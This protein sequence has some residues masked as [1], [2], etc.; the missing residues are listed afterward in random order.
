MIRG[1][2]RALSLYRCLASNWSRFGTLRGA[3]HGT[4]P[5]LEES[6]GGLPG[7]DTA[8][9]IPGKYISELHGCESPRACAGK[10]P[11]FAF[12]RHVDADQVGAK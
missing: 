1:M 3:L 2:I 11:C 5:A 7:V 9:V 6:T 10:Q 12:R 4:P 8:T